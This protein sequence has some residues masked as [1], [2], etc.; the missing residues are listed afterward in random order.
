MIIM[1]YLHCIFGLF[2]F[3]LI[4]IHLANCAESP[5]GSSKL[6]SAKALMNRLIDQRNLKFHLDAV[7]MVEVKDI[8]RILPVIR[9]VVFCRDPRRI[10]CVAGVLV[11]ANGGKI[12]IY[13]HDISAPY[14]SI[15]PDLARLAGK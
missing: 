5:D 15:G 10:G 13:K 4:G 14:L 3:G 8:G 7:E 1:K 11:F 6:E 9:F 2:L 12:E